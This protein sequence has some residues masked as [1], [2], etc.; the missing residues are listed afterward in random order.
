MEAESSGQLLL[1]YQQLLL[2]YQLLTIDEGLCVQIMYLG[3]YYDE[4][5]TVAIM[6]EFVARNGY[7]NDINENRLY[8]EIYLSDP[9][10]SEISKWKTVVRHPIIKL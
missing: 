8:H 5:D 9:Q 2:L 6:D 4:P 3:A 7:K 10:K 1:L